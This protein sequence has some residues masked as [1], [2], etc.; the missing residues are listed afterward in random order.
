MTPLKT[1]MKISMAMQ[2]GDARSAL[3]WNFVK[4]LEKL[5]DELLSKPDC[6]EEFW[7]IYFVKW[8]QVNRKI[9]EFWA[10]DDKPRPYP[11]LGEIVYHVHKSGKAEF[12]ALPM[13]IPVPESALSDEMVTTNAG[14]ASHLPLSDHQFVKI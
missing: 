14:I 4:R 2:M 10:V 1:D 13:D 9:R 11:K 3:G 7:V 8:D 12:L 6:P 5:V